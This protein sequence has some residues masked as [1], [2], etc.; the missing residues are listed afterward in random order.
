MK[1]FTFVDILLNQEITTIKF[2]GRLNKLACKTTGHS[3][4][5]D[6][7]LKYYIFRY[8]ENIF[9]FN[10]NFYSFIINEL[11]LS[12]NIFKCVLEEI[13]T[14]ILTIKKKSFLT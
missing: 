12:F 9:K 14:V 4:F 10:F 7:V 6:L 8:Y 11:S 2:E 1:T 5:I 13:Q 3:N